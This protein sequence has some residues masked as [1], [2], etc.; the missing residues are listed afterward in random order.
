M[1]N[2]YVKAALD[3]PLLMKPPE[4]TTED[5]HTAWLLLKSLKQSGLLWNKEV[6]EFLLSLG[7]SRSKVDPCLYFSRQ[8]D[9]LSVLG[10]YVDDV[11]IVSEQETDSDWAMRELGKKLDI[12]D[13][14]VANKCL[15]IT[16]EHGDDGILLHQHDTI[17]S[18]LH[19]MSM[20]ECKSVRT[21]GHHSKTFDDDSIMDKSTIIRKSIGSLLWISNCTRP[22][23]TAAA[24]TWLVSSLVRV[25][26]TG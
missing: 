16:I 13:M 18:L 21:S 7:F 15:G 10:L 23:I 5:E 12:K 2:A 6:N 1:P 3:C 25:R 26:V 24:T 11:I 22:D 4:G 20:A 14:G 9:R 19:D 17:E 8:N